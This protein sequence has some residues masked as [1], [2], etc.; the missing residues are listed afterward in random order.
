MQNG[1]SIIDLSLKSNRQAYRSIEARDSLKVMEHKV[2][3]VPNEDNTKL[4]KG[5]IIITDYGT[6]EKFSSRIS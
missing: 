6:E 2:F 4:A 1:A 5:I 3:A